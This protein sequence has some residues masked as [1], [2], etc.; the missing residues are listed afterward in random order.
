MGPQR[1][2]PL[3]GAMWIST[4]ACIAMMTVVTFPAC[5][6]CDPVDVEQSPWTG[7]PGGLFDPTLQTDPFES[8]EEGEPFEYQSR[9]SMPEGVMGMVTAASIDKAISFLGPLMT[10]PGDMRNPIKL[11]TKTLTMVGQRLGLAHMSWLANAPI[12]V[13]VMELERYQNPVVVLAPFTSKGALL[14]AL[15][16]SANKGGDVITWTHGNAKTYMKFTKRHVVVTQDRGLLTEAMRLFDDWFE[17]W[18]TDANIRIEL[19]LQALVRA[20][21]EQLKALTMTPEEV[22]EETQGDPYAFRP[23]TIIRMFF[24]HFQRIYVEARPSSDRLSVD[25][26]LQLVDGDPLGFV[27]EGAAG[28]TSLDLGQMSANQWFTLALSAGLEDETKEYL[29]EWVGTWYGELLDLTEDEMEASHELWGELFG[30]MTGSLVMSVGVE[31]GFGLTTD[32]LMQVEDSERFRV[33][34]DGLLLTLYLRG[35]PL[36]QN[37]GT[38]PALPNGEFESFEDMVAD[39]NKNFQETGISLE[40]VRT[41]GAL[42]VDGIRLRKFDVAQEENP[43]ADQ[44][45]DAGAPPTALPEPPRDRPD[46]VVD[47]AGMKRFMEPQLEFGV[48]FQGPLVAVSFGREAIQRVKTLV[49]GF[50]FDPRIPSAGRAP[51]PPGNALR[52][53]IFPGLA[54][55]ALSVFMSNIADMEQFPADMVIDASMMTGEDGMLLS[56]DLPPDLLEDISLRVH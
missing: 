36:W 38:G 28:Q 47:E 9:Y 4:L 31:R 49:S 46:N 5:S 1:N 17:R 35:L 45:P 13:A 33:L 22:A 37:S 18:E 24:D 34:Y 32:L 19:D 44:G 42:S 52:T 43:A 23:G 15:P 7:G 56:L 20:F 54:Q 27:L 12:A 53:V 55:Q 40:V 3:R 8:S 51:T 30:L 50:V 16:A 2:R 25:V 41:R 48:A 6:S 39:L 29:S 26:G 10:Q 21:P 11:R 14:D